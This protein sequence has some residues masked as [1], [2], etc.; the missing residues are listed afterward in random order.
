MSHNLTNQEVDNQLAPQSA[1]PVSTEI[2][3]LKATILA[4]EQARANILYL[5]Q[6]LAA[7]FAENNSSL[8]DLSAALSTTNTALEASKKTLA[9]LE[10]KEEMAALEPLEVPSSQNLAGNLDHSS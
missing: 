5:Q 6:Q 4:Q 3:R 2:S 9:D 8:N 10:L 1:P 7:T